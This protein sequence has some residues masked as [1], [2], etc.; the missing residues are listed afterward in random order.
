[1]KQPGFKHAEQRAALRLVRSGLS[2]FLCVLWLSTAAAQQSAGISEEAVAALAGRA[3]SEFSVPGMAIGI[4]KND[5]VLLSKGYGIREIGKADPVDAKTLFKIASNSKAFTTAAL[6]VLVDEGVISW[7]GLVIDYMPEFRMNDPWVTAGF[8]VRDLLT[9]RSG[10]KAFV[11]DMMLWP[12]PNAFTTA[13]IIHAL[14][15]FEPVSGFR[16]RYA[17]DNLLYIV[18]GEIV[19]H[20]TVM[21]WGEFVEK[22]IM[23]P[24]GMKRCFAD[25]IPK[26]EMHNIAAPHGVIEGKLSVIERSRI[27]SKLPISAAG[28][29]VVCSAGDMLT[30][31]RTQL[32]HGT[33]PGGRELFSAAQSEEMWKPQ[34]PLGVS[35]RDYELDRTHFKAYGLGWRLADVHGF[36][37]VSHTGTLAG[38]KSYVVMVPELELGVVLLTN[39]SSSAARSS[40]MNTIVRSFMPVEP[41]DWIQMALEEREAGHQEEEAAAPEAEHKEVSYEPC[42]MPD[43]SQFTGL[44]RDPWFGDVS[45]AMEDGQLV[46]S[47]D[48]SPVFKGVLSHHDG[49]RF[50]VR[51]IDRTLEADAY[52][53]FEAEPDGKVTAISMTKLDNGDFDFE[54]LQ[55]TRVE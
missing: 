50:V 46:F 33:A 14:R 37:E 24:A 44:Y 8:T 3:M 22:R 15:Y 17:Y 49:N 30:W 23:R 6:A 47:A 35:E 25:Q 54:D 27:V 29:G 48:K 32:H 26:K 11:G 1:M 18:A 43:M 10:M 45:I 21:S 2:G 5:K 19:P 40:V 16:T 13:D 7:D 4:V 55:L 36:K 53:L 38:M 34:M 28:G 31:V 52:V 41:V 51:W 12:E 42:C 20:V 39:G 9:H